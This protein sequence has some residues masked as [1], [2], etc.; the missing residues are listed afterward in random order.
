MREET[1]T[2]YLHDS[3]TE[4]VARLYELTSRLLAPDLPPVTLFRMAKLRLALA[5]LPHTMEAANLNLMISSNGIS[6][7]RHYSLRLG[8]VDFILDALHT[9]Y[10]PEIGGKHFIVNHFVTYTTGGRQ[11]GDIEEWFRQVDALLTERSCSWDIW[12]DFE[13]DGAVID[14]HKAFQDTLLAIIPTVEDTIR[15]R[16]IADSEDT[17]TMNT[18]Q[19]DRMERHLCPE[20]C[21]PLTQNQRPCPICGST[22]HLHKSFMLEL[23]HDAH[24]C[25]MHDH[26]NHDHS[27]AKPHRQQ[28]WYQRFGS[29]MALR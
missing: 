15:A 4:M 8:F 6:E 16:A 22:Y 9:S 20:C 24:I 21:A 3:D 29:W 28:R 10:D 17:P 27:P 2:Y 18:D 23:P 1:D 7:R 14:W 13:Y 25:R 26:G 11:I 5:R 12:D 19:W